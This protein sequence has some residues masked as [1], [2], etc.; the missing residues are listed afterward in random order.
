MKEK[1]YHIISC[2]LTMICGS[3]LSFPYA[4]S[5]FNK[6]VG[7]FSECNAST[8]EHMKLVF[9]PILVFSII[10]YF[11]YGKKN[12]SFLIARAIGTVVAMLATIVIYYTY[13]GI[14]GT[15]YLIIDILLYF[16]AVIYG[17]IY[18]Y[19]IIKAE[20]Y[21]GTKSTIIAISFFIIMLFLFAIF[22]FNPPH[23]GLFQDPNTGLFGHLASKAIAGL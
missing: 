10:E 19:R 21:A 2:V 5:G 3:M 14:L 12:K 13:K 6:I 18:Q 9:M 11:I 15:N 8:W 1:N 20:K 22:T 23:I 17:Y 4:A 7:V 16:V